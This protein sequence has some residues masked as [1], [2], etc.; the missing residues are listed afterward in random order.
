MAAC[1]ASR[2]SSRSPSV[3]SG[4][5]LNYL[6]RA[7]IRD[8]HGGIIH[9]TTAQGVFV[10]Q[11]VR[12]REINDGDPVRTLAAAKERQRAGGRRR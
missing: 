9:R 7:H 11:L 6:E 5:K 8:G 2:R 3:Q 10:I 12:P 1:R 4:S